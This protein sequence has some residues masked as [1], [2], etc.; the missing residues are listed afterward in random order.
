MTSNLDIT[1]LFDL[2][3]VMAKSDSFM[4]DIFLVYLHYNL[5]TCYNINLITASIASYKIPKSLIYL[6]VSNQ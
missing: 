2:C 3:H 6:K 5:L 1:S 4:T